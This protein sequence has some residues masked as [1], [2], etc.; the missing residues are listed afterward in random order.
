M[1]SGSHTVCNADL[2]SSM[3][4]AE[5]GSVFYDLRQALPQAFSGYIM[6][7]AMDEAGPKD[8]INP[9]ANRPQRDL[10]PLPYAIF[11][12]EVCQS[13]ARVQRASIAGWQLER[14]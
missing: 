11:A 5:L 12:I 7:L 3:N 13:F 2:L 8:K 6:Q 9:S 4:L 1:P 10:L 14:C